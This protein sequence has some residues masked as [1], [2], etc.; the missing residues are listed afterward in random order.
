MKMLIMIKEF[1][2]T[3]TYKINRFAGVISTVNLYSL[4]GLFSDFFLYFPGYIPLF[5]MNNIPALDTP[6][7]LTKTVY[8]FCNYY[9]QSILVL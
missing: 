5:K 2:D 7:E 9:I 1:H 3:A 4:R 8:Q 6:T